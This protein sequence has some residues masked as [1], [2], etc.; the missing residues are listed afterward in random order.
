VLLRRAGTSSHRGHDTAMQIIIFGLGYVGLVTAAGLAESGH[1]V[2]GIDVQPERLDALRAGRV[3]FHEPMLE[4]LVTRHIASGRLRFAARPDGLDADV[5]FVA[6]GTHDGNGGWQTRTILQ[7][8]EGAVPVLADATALVVRSTLPPEFAGRLGSIVADIRRQA[9]RSPLPVLVNPEFTREGTAVND[10]LHPDRVVLGVVTDPRG[11]GVDRLSALYAQHGAP[12]VVMSGV[13][14][15]L[16]KLGA[17][18]F[19]ATK[20]SFA[21]ELAG[22]CEAFGANVERVTE[23]M[24][25][26]RRIG[27]AFLRPGVGFG[28]SCLPNQV[29]MTAR[30]AAGA[31]IPTPLL[32]AVEHINAGQRE[33][34]VHRLAE[35][36]DGELRGRRFGLLGLTF[37]PDTDDLRDAPSLDIARLLL[38]EGAEVAAYDPMP[39]ARARAAALV[40]GLRAADTAVDVFRDAH[41]VGLVTEWHEFT[42]LDWV[43]LAPLMVRPR[44]VDGRNALD[45]ATLV[46]AGFSYR[47]FGRTGRPLEA[48]AELWLLPQGESV[49]SRADVA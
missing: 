14:A 1:D 13:D 25:F 32:T 10:F 3:P 26:D 24:G 17:N 40:P 41:A 6:V 43:A 18:L 33:R 22:L 31:G 11:I 8:L 2:V 29:A 4:D 49:A 46:A 38:D 27:G 7:C 20:I 47:D 44:I 19:L 48:D 28:G 12:I 5:A 42:T 36:A 15:V 37:K 16:S 30:S 23:A 39:S 45:A 9:G 34:F 35:A 21:N